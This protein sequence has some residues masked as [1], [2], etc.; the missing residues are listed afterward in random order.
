[1]TMREDMQL[2]HSTPPG[3]HLGTLILAVPEAHE[4]QVVVRASQNRLR[5]VDQPELRE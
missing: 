5:L 4:A 3:V 1:M 2:D